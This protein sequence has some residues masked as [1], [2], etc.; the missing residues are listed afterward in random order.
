MQQDDAADAVYWAKEVLALEPKNVD[1]HYVLAADP[2]EHRSPAIPEIKRHL[3]TL[4]AAKA[5]AGPARM[6]RGTAGAG[7][8]RRRAREQ[9]LEKRPGR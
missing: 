6:A 9:V 1:A 5:A 7:D 3:G 2:L 8:G 4:K